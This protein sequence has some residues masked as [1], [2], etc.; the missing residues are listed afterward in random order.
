MRAASGAIE[1]VTIDK[2]SGE[3]LVRTIDGEPAVGICG[4]GILDVTAELVRAGMVNEK[5]HLIPGMKGVRW[6]KD[7]KET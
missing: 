4:S 6:S 3:V 5:G 1:H 2:V 7:N